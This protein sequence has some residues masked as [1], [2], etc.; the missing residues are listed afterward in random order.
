MFP[1][2]VFAYKN[3]KKRF[4]LNNLETR[5]NSNSNCGNILELSPEPF[6]PIGHTG[7]TTRL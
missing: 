2:T 5:P 3:K 4:L 6:G 1:T 7:Y